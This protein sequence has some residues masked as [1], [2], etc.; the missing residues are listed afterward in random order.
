MMDPDPCHGR[1][2]GARPG[3][4]PANSQLPSNF[5][6][7]SCGRALPMLHRS[8][9]RCVWPQ[10]GGNEPVLQPLRAFS[11]TSPIVVRTSPAECA[12]TRPAQAWR[13]NN[14]GTKKKRARIS[15][16]QDWR[17]WMYCHEIRVC[18]DI[19]GQTAPRPSAR[20][21]PTPRGWRAGRA[22]PAVSRW[23]S[24]TDTQGAAWP[25]PGCQHR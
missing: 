21:H 5:C 2:V 13:V 14:R 11:T 19:G 15:R 22:R 1:S 4:G 7:R 25:W 9:P 18:A 24:A 8:K 3:N 17:A 12:K 23:G 10:D 16:H 6:G 20:P